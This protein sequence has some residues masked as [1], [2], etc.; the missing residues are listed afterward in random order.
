MLPIF[1]NLFNIM[2]KLFYREKQSA[3]YINS[4]MFQKYYVENDIEIQQKCF[5]DFCSFT[6][7]YIYII[8]IVTL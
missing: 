6:Y 7:L 2:R 8:F 4:I 1:H 3:I 5:Y